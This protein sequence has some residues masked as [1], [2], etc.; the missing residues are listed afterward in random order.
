[1]PDRSRKFAVFA[2]A[3][4]AAHAG[5]VIAF[6]PLIVLI[7]PL[8]AATIEPENTIELLSVVL[9]AGALTA[10]IGG[11]AAGW[12]S[13]RIFAITGSRIGQA[14]FGLVATLISYGVF[15]CASTPNGLV[16]AFVFYQI[17]LNI[18]FS[19]LWALLADKVPNEAKARSA[20]LVNLGI[21]IGTVVI[22]LLALSPL[23]NEA[24]RLTA[25]AS[26]VAVLVL[27]VCILAVGQ[28]NIP[29]PSVDTRIAQSTK[30]TGLRDLIFAWVARLSVQIS[31][32]VA[33]GYMLLYLKDVVGPDIGA[34][35]SSPEQALGQMGLIATPIAIALC[36]LS[37]FFGDRMPHRRGAILI[38]CASAVGV[39]LVALAIWPS[40][41]NAVFAYA[42][43]TACLT[44][45]LAIDNAV[46]AQLLA[47]S[48]SR[49]RT[50]GVMN[51]TNTL[52]S[53]LAPLAALLLA[54]QGI[55]KAVLVWLFG[56]AGLLA[57]VATIA[58]TRI[59]SAHR[60]PK[61]V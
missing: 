13:D 59:T 48:E 57:F 25:I 33:F 40:P 16:L 56:L 12:V 30:N 17:C 20:A 3:Y 11:I 7:L 54:T 43:F 47:A 19:P 24:E 42:A 5:L 45:Y 28:E 61:R 60:S 27:P 51:L 29:V 22:A 37:G 46:V 15:A 50:L 53:I 4:A 34:F 26:L 6:L 18:F 2:F 23:N 38:L 58:A 52:P 1:M 55:P 9:L 36:L 35:A 21:P 41:L 32:A 49:A 31:G 8:K 39:S 44:S 10:S 14:L